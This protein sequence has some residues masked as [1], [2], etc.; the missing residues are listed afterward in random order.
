M[1]FFESHVKKIREGHMSKRNILS[2]RNRTWANK[3]RRT[4]DFNEYDIV[5]LLDN[6][7][8]ETTGGSTKSRF[9]GPFVIEEI[10]PHTNV[11]R[12]QS[13][14]DNRYR[15]AHLCHLK[16]SVGPIITVPAPAEFK[17]KGFLNIEKNEKQKDP[18]IDCLRQSA[19]IKNRQEQSRKTDT[20]TNPYSKKYND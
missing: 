2:D 17:T 6:Q 16:P 15:I 1:K 10:F 20:N 9:I 5:Y 8:A 7:I 14:V 13:L 4:V 11:C 18:T 19:R 12:L 3:K